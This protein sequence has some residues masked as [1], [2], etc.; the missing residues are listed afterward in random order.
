[1]FSKLNSNVSPCLP[2]QA[3]YRVLLGL[4]L[5]NDRF[6]REVTRV[7]FVPE[8]RENVYLYWPAKYEKEKN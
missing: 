1:M 2:P 3:L 6:P 4:T 5:T 7:L 8:L